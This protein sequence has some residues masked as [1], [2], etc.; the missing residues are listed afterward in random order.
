MTV[1]TA[2]AVLRSVLALGCLLACTAAP[3]QQRPLTGQMLADPAAPT[4]PVDRPA[5]PPGVDLAT[6]AP[7]AAAYPLPPPRQA[8]RERP[9]SQIGDATRAALRLQAGGEQAGPRLPILG[10]QATLSY[11]RYLKSFEHPIPEYLKNTVRKDGAGASS[12]E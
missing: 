6:P 1:I 3:A 7:P 11:A 2:P 12:G 5:A 4:A 10:D 9:R 8:T